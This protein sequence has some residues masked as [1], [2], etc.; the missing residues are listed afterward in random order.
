MVPGTE[1]AIVVE[2]I[3][4]AIDGGVVEEEAIRCTPHEHDTNEEKRP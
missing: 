1:T 3:L 4:L 2:K